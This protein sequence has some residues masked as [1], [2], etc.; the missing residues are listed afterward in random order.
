VDLHGLLDKAHLDPESREAILRWLELRRADADASAELQG[1]LR[2][3]PTGILLSRNRVVE[4]VNELCSEIVGYSA[5]E[6]HGRDSRFLYADDADYDLVGHELYAP[7]WEGGIGSVETR[8]VRKDGRIVDVLLRAATADPTNRESPVIVTILDITE[9]KQA[10]AR[11]KESERVLSTLMSNLP[12]MVYRSRVDAHW[13]KLFVSEGCRELTG[14]E[15]ADLLEG[16]TVSFGNLIREDHRDRVRGAVEVALAEKV[17]FEYSYAIRVADGSERWVWERGRGVFDAEG[18]LVGIEGFI[19]DVTA[20]HRAEEER[21]ALEEQLQRSQRLESLGILAGGIAHDFN[22][23]LGAVF[24]YTE[25]VMLGL[26]PQSQERRYLEASYAAAERARDV[27]RQVLTFSRHAKP[28]RRS[29]ALQPLIR[30]ALQLARASL[31]ASVE[32]R[33]EL[34]ADCPSIVGDPTQLYQVVMNLCT[35]AGHALRGHGGLLEV[36]LDSLVVDAA[37]AARLGG[38]R[39]GPYVRLAVSD[40]GCGME[41]AIRDRVFEPFFTTK[42]PGEGTGLGLSVVHGIVTGHGGAITVYSEPRRGTTFHVYLPADG[43]AADAAELRTEL[44]VGAGEHV[45]VVDDEEL[46]AEVTRSMLESAG[47]RVTAYTDPR[48]ALEAFLADPRGF[49]LLLSDQ[50]MPH[51]SGT[52]LAERVRA[53]RADLPFLLMTGFGQHVLRQRADELGASDILA[54]PYSIVDLIGAIARALGKGAPA[55]LSPPRG[56]GEPTG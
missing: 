28:E 44:P 35:N 29:V 5:E 8:F 15:P 43:D 41:P 39:E 50:T 34:A 13:T 16:G 7:V 1:L 12:G 31:P 24:G 21:R 32:V 48:E 51:M 47:Y 53:E 11:L 3:A 54:K 2:A 9:R 45:L 20:S 27:I 25:L 19:G 14:Y 36:R 23:M 10:E 55:D 37:I 52:E 49:D 46:L 26:P 56:D 30:E 40:T 42:A 6:I 4:A 33:H 18:T 22:N 17:P 38:V